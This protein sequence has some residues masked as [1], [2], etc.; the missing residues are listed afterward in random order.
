[1]HP[2]TEEEVFLLTRLLALPVM[3]FHTVDRPEFFKNRGSVNFTF[4]EQIS[5][6][7]Y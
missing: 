5:E 6:R 1:M 3:L 7:Y 2:R 4:S